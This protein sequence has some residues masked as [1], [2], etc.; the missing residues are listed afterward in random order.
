MELRHTK[1]IIRMDIRL[2]WYRKTGP[3][4]EMV[5]RGSHQSW[6]HYCY[7]FLDRG[8]RFRVWPVVG[9]RRVRA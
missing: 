1:R 2:Y 4:V 6:V 8:R 3:Q 9:W 7:R 5:Y